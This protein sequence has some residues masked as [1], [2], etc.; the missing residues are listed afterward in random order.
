MNKHD[1]I[2]SIAT[3][4]QTSAISIIKISG[5]N[6]TKEINK[7]FTGKDLTQVASH[8]I[9]YGHIHDNELII[10]EVLISV[11][12]APHSHTGEDI[13]EIN[14]HGGILITQKI[15]D[16]VLK[17]NIR[18]ANPG[19][20]SKRAYLNGKKT[21]LESENIISLIEA[22]NE[23]ALS[24]AIHSFSNITENLIKALREDLLTIVANI[25][26]NIDYPEYDDI[27]VVTKQNITDK[28]A[29][30]LSQID[31]IITDSQKGEIISNGIKTAI[32]GKPNVGKSTLLNKLSRTDKA[33]VTNIAGTTRD[34]IESNV[35]IG[36]I[37]LNLLDTAGIRNTDDEVEKIGIQKSLETI[38]KADL[39]LYVVDASSTQTDEDLKLYDN[40]KNKNHITI[41]NK[42]DLLISKNIFTQY[43]NYILTS[44]IN[45][46]NIDNLEEIILKTFDLQ[47]FDETKAKV[48]NNFQHINTLHTVK[49][50]LE[51]ANNSLKSD[52]PID[53]VE[54]DLKEALFNLGEIL[55]LE[56]QN[57]LLDE[58]FSRFCLGK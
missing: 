45:D 22:K 17:Q 3:A 18:L 54:I 36:N 28:I 31:E 49:E 40:I 21:L 12:L 15:L 30:Y 46:E 39:I 10:D 58:L 33:I 44:L 43:D 35:N 8:T 42:S 13:I 2:A 34:V 37:M 4:V 11:M 47:A 57:N 32:I 27:T 5:H 19:E 55:G 20:F 24:L 9:N 6:I 25:E 14:T 38:N 1:N 29:G 7:I 23:K 53:L 56:V 41:I 52:I 48:L 26:V 16:L 51:S 50:H